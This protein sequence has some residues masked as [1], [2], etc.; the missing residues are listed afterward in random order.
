MDFQRSSGVLLH[1]SSLPSAGGIGDLGPA[2]H[3]FLAFLA[4]ARQHVWQV[5]PLCPTGYGNSPY[6]S[7]S[8]FA[9]NPYLISLEYL[10]D[11]GWIAP[12][13]IGGLAGRSGPV[14]FEEVEAR[15]LPLLYEAAGN[16]LDRGAQDATLRAQWEE[17]EQFCRVEA[18][19]LNDYALYAVLRAKYKTGAW[20]AWPETMRRRDQAALDEVKRD[21]WRELAMEQVLQ[22]A[23]ARQ[24]NALR[25]AAA[26]HGIRILGDVAIFVN[27]DS[28]DVWTHQDIFELDEELRPIRVA[29]VPPDYFSATGQ[30]WGN[31]LYRWDVLRDRRFDWWI[32]RMRRAREVYDIVRLDH[33]RGFEAYWAIPAAEETAVNGEWV[34]APGLELFR[35]LE[36]ALGPLPLVAED[37]GL[38]T[39]EVEALRA[40]AGFP[41]MRVVQ[42]GFSDKGA[43]IHLPHQYTPQ[44]VA[45]TGT[46]D[47]DTT[48]GWYENAGERVQEAIAAYVGEP[49]LADGKVSPVWP[50]IRAVETS[51]AQLAIVP[52]Q[53][54]LELG[55]EARMNTPAVASGNW[56]WR[57]PDGAWTAELAAKLAAL[58]EVTDRE[59]DPLEK[60]GAGSRE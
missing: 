43:H 56:S 51:V 46:H 49:P 19:W 40:T 29:G 7:S 3:E 11:W 21:Q 44:T 10:S 5:L 27:M 12:E 32:E 26:Q 59:N 34:K 30:R 2:A 31:P 55:S 58:V 36:R 33:F 48:L 42:F 1:V 23:F 22:F 60:Q 28:A 9:G 35:A 6:A 16:F 18:H 17:F 47:N 37:L 13:R 25:G 52:A 14:N 4:R 57:A 50:L 45:Y 39:K 20:S 54:L 8:A 38:I 15:K 41:G 53:D 24:W